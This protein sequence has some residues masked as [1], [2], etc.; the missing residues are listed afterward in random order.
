[1]NRRF[2]L[3]GSAALLASCT[4]SGPVRLAPG[5]TL[6]LT[7]HGDRS[8]S[9]EMLN[10][11]GRTRARALVRALEGQPLDAIYSPGIQRNLDTAAPLAGARG[12]TV[13]RI[14]Q[15]TPTAALAAA[16]AGGPVLWVGNKGNLAEIW[17]TLALPGEVPLNY[18]DLTFIRSDAEGR[19]TVERRHYGPATG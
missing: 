8:G 10:A 18:G 9:D 12:L 14:P 6:I 2:L 1:M 17:E 15:E 3:L 7:R 19:V 4:A 13:T 11:T 5:S 16:A